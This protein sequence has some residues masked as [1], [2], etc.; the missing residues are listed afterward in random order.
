MDSKTLFRVIV[1]A[2]LVIGIATVTTLSRQDSRP[3]VIPVKPVAKRTPM[4]DF[5]WPSVSGHKWSLEEHRGKIVV[6][7]FWATWCAPCREETPDLVRVYDRYKGR[8]VTI[9]G[10][11]LDDEPSKVVPR[12]VERYG[13]EYPVLVPPPDSPITGAIESIPTSFLV[14]QKGRVARTW[15]GILHEEELIRNIDELLAEGGP[16]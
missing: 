1:I 5:A 9:A 4:P 11:S 7:N 16:A 8:G 2:G 15:V 12:F 6:V 10:V 13:V 14:D 3:R